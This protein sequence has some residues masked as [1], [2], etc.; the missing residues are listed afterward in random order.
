[1]QSPLSEASLARAER[2][3]SCLEP[4]VAQPVRGRLVS[5]ERRRVCQG[6]AELAVLDL[7]IR[8]GWGV[9]SVSDA[10]GLIWSLRPSGERVQAHVLAFLQREPVNAESL[11]SLETAL[12]RVG[13]DLRYSVFVRRGLPAAFDPEPVRRSVELWLREVEAGRWPGH[14]AT[15]EEGAIHLEFGLTGER[16]G[17]SGN[18]V[19]LILG[20]FLGGRTRQV[21]EARS[22]RAMDR[23]VDLGHQ[24]DVLLFGV[25]DGPWRL[26]ASY[27][28]EF[29]YGRPSWTRSATDTSPWEFC[30]SADQEP[31]LFKQRE[32]SLLAGF[33]Q[34]GGVSQGSPVLKGNVYSNPFAARPLL[35]EE[36][37]L[38]TLQSSRVEAPGPVMQWV[39]R[40]LV[41]FE[42]AS[43]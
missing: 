17:D 31:C 23:V 13:S 42:L 25:A 30:L 12:E 5:P 4:E 38:R 10:G 22:V 29:L 43:S 27:L 2:L 6:L 18:P 16:V 8:S 24:E 21:L 40:D 32:Y 34:I 26:S 7:L 19:A 15:Y 28:Q 9:E 35:G 1:M 11:H 3:L 33:V 41:G 39:N 36:L 20:P 37:A 14:Y